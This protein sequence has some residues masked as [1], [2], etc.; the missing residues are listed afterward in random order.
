M[1]TRELLF[2]LL[3]I[4]VCGEQPTEEIKNACTEQALEAVFMLAK[5]HDIAHLVGH[6]IS[7]LQLQDSKWLTFG[8]QIAMQACVRHIRQNVD[9]YKVCALLEEEK[10]PF[11]PLKGSVLRDY[12]PEPWM[13]TSCDVDILV[14][15]EDMDAARALLEAQGWS[16]MSS[17]AH[18]ISLLSSEKTHLELHY[19]AIEDYVSEKGKSIMDDVWEAAAP[20]P[21]KQCH[22]AI[23]DPLFYYYHMAHMAKHFVMGGCGIRLFLDIWI[24][25]NK[26]QFDQA[27]RDALLEKGDV[28][29]FARGAEK[30][31]RIWFCGEQTDPM[32]A[33][34]EDFV[35]EGGSYGTLQ[36][37]VSLQQNQ[38]GGKLKFVLK[39]IF[40]PYI[41]LKHSYP[42]LE[43]HKWLM[44]V[45]QV[46]RWFK[47]LFHGRMKRSV[48]ELQVT[49]TVSDDSKNRT[50][51]LIEYLGL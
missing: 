41:Y 47:M 23:S 1:E 43:K 14:H 44:P 3:R 33:V 29:K 46:M 13:R 45:C 38:E 36:N 17:S 15:P 30:L 42:V 21:G 12:Y 18:D 32:S 28:L 19:A 9:Y 10:I 5:K 35:L 39:R 31:S 27:A 7:K 11:I 24:L 40:Q 20:L 26:M 50:K 2:A 8:N 49:T 6:A 16:Y 4:A 37:R 48:R 34:M 25:Q 51:K 22:M